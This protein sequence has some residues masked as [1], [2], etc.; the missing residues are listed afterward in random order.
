MFEQNPTTTSK[1]AGWSP[2]FG[3]LDSKWTPCDLFRDVEARKH[4]S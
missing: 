3:E 1:A 2:N 4:F